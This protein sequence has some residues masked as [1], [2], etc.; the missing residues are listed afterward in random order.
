MI[1]RLD[2]AHAE[3]V[4]HRSTQSGTTYRHKSL[5]GVA[6]QWTALINVVL[7][8]K[9]QQ[10]HAVDVAYVQIL[11]LCRDSITFGGVAWLAPSVQ[12]GLHPWGYH[13]QLVHCLSA[14]V[15]SCSSHDCRTCA[16]VCCRCMILCW[17]WLVPHE[18]EGRCAQCNH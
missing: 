3:E 5:M 16:C 18:E 6:T 1:S 13:L 4:L 9:G 11:D 15:M 17:H 12:I 2:A 8:H 14:A 7:F 10:Q